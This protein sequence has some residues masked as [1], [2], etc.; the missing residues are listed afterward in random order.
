VVLQDV[1]PLG[2]GAPITVIET[3]LAGR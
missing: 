2:T 1:E 3:S